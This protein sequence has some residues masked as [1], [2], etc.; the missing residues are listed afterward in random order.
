K[1]ENSTNGTFLNDH[2]IP[3]D[4]YVELSTGDKI[5]VGTASLVMG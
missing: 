3:S 2:R 4:K 5:T 1:D